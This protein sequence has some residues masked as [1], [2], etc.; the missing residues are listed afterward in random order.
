MRLRF[1]CVTVAV[2][3]VAVLCIAAQNQGQSSLTVRA[4]TYTPDQ[5]L[6]VQIGNSGFQSVQVNE[7]S[8]GRN[9]WGNV[10]REV[11]SCRTTVVQQRVD[12]EP[13]AVI[14]KTSQGQFIYEL[15][16]QLRR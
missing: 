11:E 1:C 8:C 15:E 14:L 4:W 12:S 16:P 2:A 7:M 13:C 5:T 9:T 3:V 10:G 6:T